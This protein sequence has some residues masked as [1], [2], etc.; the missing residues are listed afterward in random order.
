MTLLATGGALLLLASSEACAPAIAP[1]P[2]AQKGVSVFV[3]D[4]NISWSGQAAVNCTS[5]GAAKTKMSD[6]L[7][8]AGY[9][10]VTTP[11]TADVTVTITEPKCWWNNGGIYET[12]DLRAESGG[13]ILVARQS[14]ASHWS[15][16]FANALTGAVAA[17]GVRPAVSRTVAAPTTPA[18]VPAPASPASAP[19]S[20]PPW[21]VPVKRGAPQ[22]NAYALVIGIEKY[23]D[24]PS[25]TGARTDAQ[26]F[27]ELATT[28]FGVPRA[29]VVLALDDHASKGDLAKHLAWLDANVPAEGRIYLYF[30]GH[31]SPDPSQGTAYLL[32]YDGDPK[33]LA[34][35]AYRVDDLLATLSRTKAK[36]VFAFVDACYSGAG[37]RSVLPP[38]ARALAKVVE[39]TVAA[40]QAL[41]SGARAD[42]ISGPVPG[43]PIGLFT[44]ML[45]RGL[46]AGEADVDGDGNVS[47]DELSQWVPPRVAREA[48]KDNRDQNPTLRLSAGF[49]DAKRIVIASGLTP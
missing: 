11:S 44:Q 26:R 46:G 40:K 38:G 34:S 33:L 5:A 29:N 19:P 28:S 45:V 48:K 15:N 32:P 10:V 47:L 27:A 17:N 6:A 23:R 37:G 16:E 8:S 21:A 3:G 14:D 22:P 20:T 7:V 1:L 4:P 49:G 12:F 39:P 9:R 13:A 25:P 24:V 2:P 35:S 42:E 43:Q 31:G 30:A 36:E 18:V 41:F